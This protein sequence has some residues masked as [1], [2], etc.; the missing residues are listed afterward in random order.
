MDGWID[1]WL[2]VGGLVC[3]LVDKLVGE[4]GCEVSGCHKAVGSIY[5]RWL[6]Y[7]VQHKIL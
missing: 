6:N 2:I 1:G 5:S 7:I 3:L 4:V